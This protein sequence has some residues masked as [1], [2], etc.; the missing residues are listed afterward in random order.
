M[1]TVTPLSPSISGTNTSSSVSRLPAA[2]A[3]FI[4][5]RQDVGDRLSASER[6]LSGGTADAVRPARA[7]VGRG[8]TPGA[9]RRRDG[10]L[11]PE[12]RTALCNQDVGRRMAMLVQN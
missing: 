12:L 7:I 2:L 9:G 10:I 4:G 6:L 3:D 5:P 1:P 11:R 8:R